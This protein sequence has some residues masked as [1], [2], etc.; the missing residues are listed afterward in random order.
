M[1]ALALFVAVAVATLGAAGPAFA[2]CADEIGKLEASL[3]KQDANAIAANSGGQKDAAARGGKAQV[4]KKTGT[5]VQDLPSPGSGGDVRESKVA[6]AAGSGGSDVMAAK[7]T[8]NEAKNAEKRGDEKAC[9]EAVSKARGQGN[10]GS[11]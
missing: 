5:P 9:L 10:K 3:N 1:S 2:G 11:T 7:V 4:A 8:L 6:A